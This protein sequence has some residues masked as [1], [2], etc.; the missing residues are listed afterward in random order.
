M[1][2]SPRPESVH[3]APA[4]QDPPSKEKGRY[5]APALEK[6]L[7]I[8]ELI[9]ERPEGLS[10]SEIARALGRTVGEIFR[11]LNCLVE[12]G[13]LTIQR[14]GDRYVVT[15][16]VFELAHRH[17]V[18]ERLLGN[19]LPLMKE[20]ATLVHQSCHLALIEGGHATVVAHVDSPGHVGFSVRVG[21]VLSLPAT[22]AGR[23]LLAFQTPDD[24]ARFLARATKDSDLGDLAALGAALDRI[25]SRG[26][27]DLDGTRIRGVHD[28][29]VPV[30]DQRGSAIAA[31]TVPY[32]DRLDVP[33]AGSFDRARDALQNCAARLAA[34]LGGRAGTPPAAPARAR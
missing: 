8:L 28:V 11:M 17:G 16:K 30:L 1:P 5:R 14:P 2:D 6:G 12:R 21:S 9:A 22:A 33:N 19:A 25:R 20:L 26:Y 13:Y 29:A 31:I 24:R 15:F 32:L 23:V 18:V 34:S 4:L 10:Q 27:E 7:D 3:K